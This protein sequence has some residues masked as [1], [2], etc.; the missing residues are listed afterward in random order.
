MK[1][2]LRLG[3]FRFDLAQCHDLSIPLRFDGP[4]PRHFGAG[5]AG[6]EPMRAGGF[7][8]DTRQGGSC[9][10][11]V[12]HINPHCNGT[13]TEC[14]GHVTDQPVSVPEVGPAAP[15]LAALAS[16]EPV[17]A[18]DCAE[19]CAGNAADGDLVVSAAS[20]RAALAHWTPVALEALVLRTLPN[21][22]AKTECDYG[23]DGLV[24][25]YFTLDAM[26]WLVTRGILHLVCDLPSIDRHHDQGA[27]AGHRIFWGLP[28]G[29]RDAS[30]A[31]RPGATV[32]EMA[33][34]P[35]AVADGLYALALH[36]PALVTDAVPS[37]P[38]IYPRCAPRRDPGAG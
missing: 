31:T 36:Y 28:A 1:R 11:R 32:T 19:R 9:N 18:S 22:P 13:H 33:F 24:T 20:L 15:C 25:P 3:E 26:Q 12:L 6:A 8:G 30:A 37:R 35:D 4:Q 34:V 7:V 5:P 10:A 23:A 2:E 27:L 14:L 38:L 29:S 16:V 17:S 21:S